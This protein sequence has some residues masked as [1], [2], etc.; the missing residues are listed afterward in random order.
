[1]LPFALSQKLYKPPALCMSA[2]EEAAIITKMMHESGGQAQMDPEEMQA[3]IRRARGQK[4]RKP[5]QFMKMSGPI[6]M[7]SMFIPNDGFKFEVGMPFSQKFQ[8][9][10]S[11]QFSNSKSPELEM[12]AMLVHGNSMMM[13]DEMSLLQAVSHSRG[14]QVVYQ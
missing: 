5:P 6:K 10:F 12:M 2:E 11:W 1:M 9:Q 7:M 8:T 3:A 13:E 14:K 4:N